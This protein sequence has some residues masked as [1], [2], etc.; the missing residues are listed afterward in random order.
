MIHISKCTVFTY[1]WLSVCFPILMIKPCIAFASV[2]FNDYQIAE[3]ID[4]N[5]IKIDLNPFNKYETYA[6]TFTNTGDLPLTGPL[7]LAIENISTISVSVVWPT[8]ISTEG[9]PY[10]E[11]VDPVFLPGETRYRFVIFRKLSRRAKFTFTP[12]IYRQ[13]ESLPNAR[14][15]ANAGQDVTTFVS[16]AVLL[17]GS[18]STDA[19]GDSLTYQWSFQYKAVGSAATLI[20]SNTLTPRLTIDVPGTY[21]ISL[22]VN[23]GQDDSEPDTV[24][25]ST[26]NSAPVAD[27]GT[28][29][30]VIVGDIVQLDGTNSSDVDGDPLSYHWFLDTRPSGSS[31]SLDNAF[32]GMPSFLVDLPGTYEFDLVVN[33]GNLDSVPDRVVIK[34]RNSKPLADAGQDIDAFVGDSVILDGSNSHD[35]DVDTLTYQWS[36]IT[37]P[38]G[39]ISGLQDSNTVAPFFVPDMEGIYVAQLIVND[40]AI[41]SDPDTARVN[42]SVFVPPDSDGDGLTDAEEQLLGTDPDIPDTDEDGLND[43]DEVTTYNTNPLDPDTDGDNL[44]DG[45]EINQFLTDPLLV[46]TDGDGFSDDVEISAGSDPN[47]QNDTLN[48]VLPRDPATVAPSLDRTVATSVFTATRFLY[49]GNNPIQTGVVEEAIEPKRTA[50]LRGIVRDRYDQPLSGV[51]VTILGHPEFGQTI[52]RL[53]GMFDM[54]VNGGSNLTVE[55]E[56]DGYLSV[57]RIVNVPWQDYT[58]LP[59][60]VMVSVDPQ[61]TTIEL[62]A[63]A[64]FQV[65]QGRVVTDSD[66]SRQATLLFSEGTHATMTMPDGTIQP[67]TTMN[68]RATE[69]TV[70]DNGPESMP[71][72]LPPS[73]GYTYAVEYTVDEAINAHATEVQFDKP[74]ITYLENFIG[75]PVGSAVPAGYYD[76]I[77]SNWVSSDNGRVIQIL[78]VNNGVVDIDVD[79]SGQPADSTMLT[80]LGIT[81]TEREQLPSLYTS[82]QTLWRVPITHFT[83]WDYNWPYGAPFDAKPPTVSNPVVDD[84]DKHDDPNCQDSSIIECENQIL[85]ESI[86]VAGTPFSLNYSSDR[87]PG[88]NAS[89]AIIQLSKDT[90]PASLKRIEVEITIAGRRLLYTFP[91]SPLQEM[92]FNWDGKDAYGRTL[93]GAQYARIKIIYVYDAIYLSQADFTRRYFGLPPLGVGEADEARGE[94]RLSDIDRVK[95]I[96]GSGYNHTQALG[97]WSLNVVHEYVPNES[98]LYLGTGGRRTAQPAYLDLSTIIST[99]AGDGIFGYS[100]DGE[101]ALDAHLGGP[102]D[103]TTAAD[104]SI[105]IAD[106]ANN[107][108]RRVAPDGTITTVAGDGTADFSGDGG[109]ATQ[110]ALN[111]PTAVSIGPNGELLISDSDNFRVRRVGTNGIITTVVGSLGPQELFS[112]SGCPAAGGRPGIPPSVGAPEGCLATEFIFTSPPGAVAADSDGS[113]YFVVPNDSRIFRVGPDGMVWIAAGTGSPGYNGD[114]IPAVQAQIRSPSDLL[115]APDGTLIFSDSDN[116]RVRQISV[117]GIVSTIA[118]T[119]DSDYTGDNGPAESASL[120]FP[121]GI[122]LDSSRAL[123]I[124][125]SGNN[126]VRKISS[127]GMIHTVIGN[128]ASGQFVE[129]G[130]AKNTFIGESVGIAIGPDGRIF[131][132]QP[133]VNRLYNVVI[134]LPSFDGNEIII[135]SKEGDKLYHFDQNGRHV[136][137]TNAYTGEVL[138]QFEYQENY[139]A[140]IT[141]SDGN[142]TLIERDPGTHIPSAIISPDGLRTLLTLSSGGYLAQIS[143]PAGEHY[144]F[145]YSQDGL[146]ETLTDPRGNSSH[147]QYDLFG[148]LT[149]DD[150]A[151]GGGWDLERTDIPFGSQVDMTSA[152]GHLTSYTTEKVFSPTRSVTGQRRLTIN[153]DG[154]Q[155]ETISLNDGSTFITNPDGS[156]VFTQIGP[157]P[158]LGIQAPI[159]SEM[160]IATPSGLTRT[161]DRERNILPANDLVLEDIVTINGRSFSSIFDNQDL[162]ITKTTPLG[163]QTVMNV[164]G[165]FKVQDTSILG[166]NPV[167]YSYDARGRLSSITDGIGTDTRTTTLSYDFNGFVDNITDPL[168]RNISFDYDAAGRVTHRTL[169]DGRFVD[170]TYDANGNVTSITPPGRSAHV[171]NYIPVNLEQDYTPPIVS[172]GAE[173]TQYT[174]NLDKQLTQISRPDGRAID[175]GYDTFGRLSSTTFSRGSVNYSYDS[176]G[177]LNQVD[178]PGGEVLNFTYDGVLP[179]TESWSGAVSGSVDL[180]Y[181]NNF[182]ISGVSVNASSITYSHDND[183]LLTQAGNL[184]LNRDALNGLLVG[185]SLGSVSTSNSYNGFGERQSMNSTYG[186][187]SLY[188]ASYTRDKLGRITV[189]TE[190]IEGTTST[191]NYTYDLA[192][193][194]IEVNRDGITTAVYNYDGNSNRIGGTNSEGPISATY[195]GQ[196]KLLTYNGNVYNYNAN[197]DLLT[198]T[199]QTAT[200]SYNYDEFGN[201]TRVSLPGDMTIDYIVDGNNRRIG[202]KVNGTMT[203]GFLYQDQLNPVAELDGSNNVDSRFVYGSKSNVP[204]YMIKG[205]ITYRIIS[206]HLG[207]PRL[208]VNINDG[209]I[210]QRMDYGEF[211]NILNDTNPGFQPFGFAGGIYD[212]HTGL[213]RFG[214]RDYDTQI[215]RWTSKDPIRFR[216]GDANLYGYVLDDPVNRI[217]SLG[218]DW[219]RPQ[220]HPYKVGRPGTIVPEGKGEIGGYL[221]DYGPAWHTTG[222]YHDLLVETATLYGIPDTLIN[223]PTI[224]IVYVFSVGV[225]IGNS[226]QRIFG[227]EGLQHI[228]RYRKTCL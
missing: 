157:D 41:D 37:V 192:G 78:S 198:K 81:T 115:I 136:S 164:D 67:L 139:L 171:F 50:L 143:N 86:N 76:R 110:A 13:A 8:T 77:N 199:A 25:I 61:V 46:D 141:D 45:D 180:S 70:G 98:T 156:T 27:V 39:S 122:A 205:G 220:D 55:Y 149:Q 80:T 185:T 59:D 33:D 35:P 195:D 64:P 188:N 106:S 123:Y 104:G 214:A 151:A 118:G 1:L 148:R 203:Q 137:T 16:D 73:S 201:L 218:L 95:L 88:R 31:A 150:N 208:V 216:G 11:I 102:R 140:D 138:Y 207:S 213:V 22:V 225:E 23:D 212:Q 38:E 219:F 30:S 128:G 105:Y 177:R 152:L 18:G 63:A 44:T 10:H 69:Y 4:F 111:N 228:P 131:I 21:I 167:S 197:G 132:P 173:V 91:P 79:G 227:Y 153:P 134:S 161:E 24:E 196:D 120:N 202:K 165:Q 206:D 124:M 162:S 181:D 226:I 170:Y 85:R 127:D 179:T 62:N 130:L 224:P 125:D 74:V 163:R 193:R 178:D 53:D 57:Q 169:P 2:S 92:T 47:N 158:R 65:A 56:R 97:G 194:L 14:P 28:D 9:V 126:R 175:I 48:G 82:G 68:V 211:G 154:T 15:V 200:T 60:I 129:G 109:L 155:A 66:G 133:D 142:T 116:N 3:D 54:A 144:D 190:T 20:D 209:S 121:T 83:P 189:L 36:L 29:Q 159:T 147:M 172:T 84:F 71:A 32:I 17:D 58:W 96:S 87:A 217:D 114:S 107:R 210:A 51:K 186:G 93:Q 117:D 145:S 222:Y 191:F 168:G 135:P 221:D 52:T 101:L 223:I 5:S 119:G 160:V 75:F 146:L 100:G 112:P 187:T 215:G 99:I 72:E 40:G 43:G 113:L 34:T 183:G 108:I 12:I 6:I 182:W 49:T 184:I 94:I 7:Y 103:V 19:D 90:V 42:T 166:L 26:L 176:A 89:S 174:Y 204:D